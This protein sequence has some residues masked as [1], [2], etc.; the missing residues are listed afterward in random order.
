MSE[1]LPI[2]GKDP[3]GRVIR[4]WSVKPWWGIDRKKIEWYPKVNY[5]KCIGCGVCYITCANRVVFDWDK[6]KKKP[7]VARPYNCVVACTTCKMLCPVDALEFP[8]KEYMEKIIKEHKILV[9]AKEILKK[10]DLI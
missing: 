1:E 6:E 5:D 7:V 10:H 9:K 4:D 8:D 3:L 2:I